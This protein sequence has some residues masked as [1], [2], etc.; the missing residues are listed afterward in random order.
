MIN[1]ETYMHYEE[2]GRLPWAVFWIF[3]SRV[4]N[5]WADACSVNYHNVTDEIKYIGKL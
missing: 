4:A 3:V 2:E 5:I 1:D